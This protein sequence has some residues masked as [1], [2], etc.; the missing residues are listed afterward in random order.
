MDLLKDTK[1]NTSG[2]KATKVLYQSSASHDN[3]PADTEDTKIHRWTLELLEK[4]VARDFKK[5]VRYEN[6]FQVS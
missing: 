4:N 2:H 6:L 3:T 5:D 1:K